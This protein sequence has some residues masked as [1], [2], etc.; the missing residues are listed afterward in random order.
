M[1][2]SIVT[3]RRRIFRAVLSQLAL[4]A[5]LGAAGVASAQTE[6]P[7][8]PPAA[9]SDAQ[10][11]HERLKALLAKPGGLTARQAS[12]QAIATSNELKQS[13]ADVKS[14]V[15][16]KDQAEVGYLPRVTLTARY[17]RLS[18]VD[19]Q[20]LGTLVATTQAGP[21]APGQPLI[22]VDVSFP[23]ILNQYLLQAN[24]TV[25]LT[26]YFLR[27]NHANRAA[28]HNL[29]A[30]KYRQQVTRKNAALQAQLAYYGWAQSTLAE[31]IA[32]QTLDQAQAH[33]KA[34]EA[35]RK[36]D[37][38]TRAEL[39]RFDAQVANAELLLER[40]RSGKEINADTL[41]TLLHDPETKA[42]SIGEDLLTPLPPLKRHKLSELQRQAQ[43]RRPEFKAL[44][45]SARALSSQRQAVKASTLPRLDAFGNAYYANPHQRAFPQQDKWTGSWDAGL[46]LTYVIND[47]PTA[48]A[49]ARSLDAKQ[50]SVRAQESSLKDMLRREL[51]QAQRSAIEADVAL[52]VAAR[53]LAASEEAYR[54]TLLQFRAERAKSVDLIDA[55]TELLRARLEL[56]TAHINQRVT[57]AKLKYALGEAL[58]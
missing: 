4:S 30:A 46:Q 16:D 49:S 29:Q 57:R 50:A 54:A 12:A 5:A 21:V 53:G 37:T 2:S 52:K 1:K 36:A 17:T 32:E 20:S 44:S 26:D 55:N 25:P 33:Y 34:A 3:T 18:E 35:G 6:P 15:A 22:G 47:L 14:A 13:E 45:E 40:A 10:Q 19:T 39:M 58:N 38:L 27:T 24:V 56:I 28:G 41:R 9:K 7:A 11:L 51:S 43:R 31:V 42:Y 48:N 23:Q 8:A